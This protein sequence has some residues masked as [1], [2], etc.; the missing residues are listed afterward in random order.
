MAYLYLKPSFLAISIHLEGL[1]PHGI[2]SSRLLVIL[3]S[4]LADILIHLSLGCTMVQQQ[5]CIN[6][7]D[8]IGHLF[9]LEEEEESV[10]KC[11]FPNL[12]AKI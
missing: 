7:V 10:G 6:Q 9:F 3:L 4:I 11:T 12:Q 2:I 5:H 1:K 8:R